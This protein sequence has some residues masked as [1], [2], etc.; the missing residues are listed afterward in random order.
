M[1]I[2]LNAELETGDLQTWL[3]HRAGDTDWPYD[4]GPVVDAGVLEE[5][6]WLPLYFAEAAIERNS[7]AQARI[8]AD[9]LMRR[10]GG[11]PFGPEESAQGEEL[12]DICDWLHYWADRGVVTRGDRG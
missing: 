9:A 2:R 5:L 11:H 10:H 6:D 1:S 7:P 8:L 12:R 4:R 3:D